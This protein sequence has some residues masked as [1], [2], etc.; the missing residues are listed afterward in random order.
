MSGQI[1]FEV[2]SKLGITVRITHRHWQLITEQKHL[3]IKGK[4]K[5]IIETLKDPIEI[6]LSRKDPA[7]HLYYQ[8]SGKYFYCTVVKHLNGEGFI[9]T[10]Y[11]T[12]NIKEG[13][14]VWKR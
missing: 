4:E 12:K 6:R 1:L 2:V 5:E 8:K 10:A 14:R 3:E 13:E 7:V 9:I 11:L